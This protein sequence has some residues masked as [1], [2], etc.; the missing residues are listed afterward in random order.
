M[1][2]VICDDLITE[3]NY[4]LNS[5]SLNL[6]HEVYG[7][8]KM[9]RKMRAITKD[10]FYELNDKLIRKRHKQSESGV[11]IMAGLSEIITVR[12]S[13]Y[14]PCIVKCQNALFHRWEDN[15]EIYAP[16]PMVGGHAGGIVKYTCAIV[17]Y[18]DGHVE[19]VKPE[20]VT[21]VDHLIKQYAFSA[22]E[23]DLPGQYFDITQ[24]D[25]WKADV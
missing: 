5:K 13:E 24:T 11:E 23:K 3:A 12:N 18:E 8:A 22:E 19:R 4:A 25:I 7:Q 14:R 2:K 15:S 10:Q 1:I 17:E 16:S 21:F 9:A 20:D 6:V